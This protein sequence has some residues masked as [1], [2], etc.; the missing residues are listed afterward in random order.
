[1]LASTV[2]STF[3]VRIVEIL[4]GHR[5]RARDRLGLRRLAQWRWK[6]ENAGWPQTRPLALIVSLAIMLPLV[7]SCATKWEK[8]GATEAEFEGTKSACQA[9]SYSQFPPLPQQVMIRS[10]YTTPM[11]TQCFGGGYY[12]SCDTTGGQYFPASYMT[13]DNN[14]GARNSAV[15]SCFFEHGWTPQKSK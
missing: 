7:A 6:V 8:P 14:Q 1:M 5:D 4:G 13:V 12:L 9:Q 15:R 10:G 3:E 11:Q 2:L